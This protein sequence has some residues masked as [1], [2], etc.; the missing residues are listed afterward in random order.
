MDLVPIK[1]KIG[2]KENGQAKYP[3]FN[4]LAATGG[5][6]WS[7]YIDANGSGWLY[8]CCGHKEAEANSP[9]GQQWGMILVP[10]AFADEAI[11]T[12]PDEVMKLTEEECENFYN[13]KHARDLPDEDIDNNILEGIK[14]KQD[15]QQPLTAQQTK[16]LDPDD[17]T[18]GVRKNK[19]KLWTDYKTLTSIKIVQ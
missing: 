11:A 1:V 10:Q 2:L 8:D 5:V 7:F 13:D 15:L 12:F 6:D 14:L 17:D 16:A 4:Q 3:D 9:M 19:R 18:P